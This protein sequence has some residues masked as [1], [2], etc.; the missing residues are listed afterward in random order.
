LHKDLRID[1]ILIDKNLNFKI[2]DFGKAK[3]CIS[4]SHKAQANKGP[5]CLAPESY[6]SNEF[7]ERSDIYQ[8]GLACCEIGSL[9][10]PH[11]TAEYTEL[12][13]SSKLDEL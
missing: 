2:S 11:H 8:L 10:A 3:Q 5:I 9:P 6:L 4:D 1:N 13:E 7:T 12:L